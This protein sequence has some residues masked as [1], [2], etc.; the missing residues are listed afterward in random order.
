MTGSFTG[1]LMEAVRWFLLMTPALGAL[2]LVL[3]FLMALVQVRLPEERVRRLFQRRRATTSYLAGAALGAVTP[4]C[5]MTTIPVLAVLLKSGVPFGP[6]MAFLISSPLLDGIVLGVLVFL[7]GPKLTALYAAVT[8]LA[9]IGLG[10]LFAWFGLE[11]DVKDRPEAH[12]PHAGMFEGNGERGPEPAA[13]FLTGV[14]A[15]EPVR[16]PAAPTA[17]R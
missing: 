15:H 8:F 5:S 17:W 10:A 1:N 4:F 14:P 3:I 2:F 6:T 11:R 9:S 13:T 7:I 12:R 16:R